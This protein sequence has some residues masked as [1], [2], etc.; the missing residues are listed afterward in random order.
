MPISEEFARRYLVDT[1]KGS[2][3]NGKIDLEVRIIAVDA[4]DRLNPKP[5]LQVYGAFR[6][7]GQQGQSTETLLRG[8]FY[9]YGGFLSLYSAKP[10]TLKKFIEDK[11]GKSI[12]GQVYQALKAPPTPGVLIIVP[13]TDLWQGEKWYRAEFEK[14]Y[15]ISPLPDDTVPP[16][17]ALSM[18]IARDSAG[19]GWI[20]S[21]KGDGFSDCDEVI[22]ASKKGVTTSQLP[23]ITGDLAL[24]SRAIALKTIYK[25]CPYVFLFIFTGLPVTIF[26]K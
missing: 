23:P 2:T 17:V 9:L 26:S 3:C 11:Y 16:P 4:P 14:K 10:I 5:I 20:G 15:G 18:D 13:G 8:Q 25:T 12:G 6:S 1:Y 22:I 24:G 21:F 7:S 19:K